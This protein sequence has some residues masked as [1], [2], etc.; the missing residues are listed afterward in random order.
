MFGNSNAP[1]P[2]RRADRDA[3]DRSAACRLCTV[4]VA[5]GAGG[6]HD[7]AGDVLVRTGVKEKSIPV[8]SRDAA[9]EMV[10]AAGIGVP[11]KY[12]RA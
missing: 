9:T 2:P 7:V 6:I 4:P 12:D 5:L 10:A 11:G 1:L 3:S 8:R